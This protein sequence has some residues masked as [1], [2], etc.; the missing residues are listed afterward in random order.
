[1]NNSNTRIGV[2]LLVL[3]VLT[4][5]VIDYVYTPLFNPDKLEQLIAAQNWSEGK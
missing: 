2:I 3:I 5:R 4:I 1:M